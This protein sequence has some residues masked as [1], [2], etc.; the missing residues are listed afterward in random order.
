[1]TPTVNA[2]VQR[3]TIATRIT[4]LRS[5]LRSLS[6]AP[7][8]RGGRRPLGALLPALAW[9]A[10]AVAGGLCAIGCGSGAQ[11]GDV[12]LDL[13]QTGLATGTQFTVGIATTVGTQTSNATLDVTSAATNAGNSA[14][15]Q[16]AE[17]STVTLTITKQAANEYC[18]LDSLAPI[19][20]GIGDVTAH[21]TCSA[22]G[23]HVGVQISG[24]PTAG[25]PSGSSVVLQD[26]GG[27]KLTA[28]AN[29]PFTFAT[30]IASGGAYA[31]TI[32]TQPAGYTCA[33]ATASP[34]PASGTI[35]AADVTNIAISCAATSVY[36]VF[37]TVA[38][39]PTGGL[40]APNQ[41][42]LQNGADTLPFSANTTAPVAFG[43]QVNDGSTYAVTI[44]TPAAGYSCQLSSPSSGSSSVDVTVNVTCSAGS[45]QVGV[46]VTGLPTAGL[47]AP[48]QLV[49]ELNGAGDQQFTANTTAPV[50][51]ANAVADNATFAV[52]VKTQP[53]GFNCTASLATGSSGGANVTT[54]VVS[55]VAGTYVLAATVT[56][57]AS[58]ESLTFQDNLNDKVVTTSNTTGTGTIVISNAFPAGP[59]TVT[60]TVTPAN[61]TCTVA[62]GSGTVSNANVTVSVTCA[63]GSL[64]FPEGMYF[65]SGRNLLYVAN[66]GGNNVLVYSEQSSAGVFTGLTLVTT[67][68]TD[69]NKPNGV[70]LDANG[71]LYVSNGGTTGTSSVT[72]YDT[73]NSYA[74]ITVAAMGTGLTLPLFVAVDQ[75][76]YVYVGDEGNNAVS[77]F[78]QTGTAT[79]TGPTTVAHDGAAN[80]F[81]SPAAVNFAV[82]NGATYLF[83]GPS[84]NWVYLYATPFTATSTPAY[85]I[86]NTVSPGCN[87]ASPNGPTA[88]AVANGS[89][90]IVFVANSFSGG[91]VT[92]YTFSSIMASN[93]NC[94][95]AVTSSGASQIAEPYGLA[96]DPN[97]NTLFVS[98][99]ATNTINVYGTATSGPGAVS[100]APRYVQH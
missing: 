1:M 4:A 92:G 34:S 60:A 94:S 96:V 18:S 55:C 11:K 15:A 46:T 80:A 66:E 74:E 44:A 71:Y 91:N 32:L 35:A 21:A 97:T 84:T 62:N 20:V 12:F 68:S 61:Q 3:R 75:F 9:T 100:G 64:N 24:L 57:L 49:L 53:T 99:T 47:A 90:T 33:V 72:V 38:G 6:A 85:A 31:V 51:F 7:L 88:V 40:T 56:G 23:Y 39:L 54:P 8:G 45:Y 19:A 16:V 29:G 37:A 63:T 79:F 28:S 78:H 89:P 87:P 67:I 82:A 17:N 70:A 14:Q 5:G 41:L 59:Y 30:E 50:L 69:V 81:T 36:S 98:N 77:I 65:D 93:N 48:N 22:Q 27:D 42:V 73:N 13:T 25:L 83:V 76:G 95:P 10:C 58:G 2:A 26:V 43:H 86:T 52:T